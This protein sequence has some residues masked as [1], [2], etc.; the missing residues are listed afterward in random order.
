MARLGRLRGNRPAGAWEREDRGWTRRQWLRAGAAAG[1][2]IAA[3][4]VTAA[5]IL[6][7]PILPAPLIDERLRYLRHSTD[8]WWNALDGQVVRVTDFTEWSG[9]TAVWR[10]LFDR[11]DRFVSGTGYRV[12]VIRVRRDDNV[13]RASGNVTVPTGYSLFYDDPVRDVRIVVL[14]QRCTHLCCS[15]SWHVV[16]EPPPARDYE[17]YVTNPQENVPTYYVYGQDPIYCIC[18]GAQ[19]EPM[20]L[21]DGT[22]PTGPSYIGARLVHGPGWGPLPVVVVRARDDVLEGGMIDPRWYSF[23]ETLPSETS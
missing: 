4:G 12:L 2:A 9:A 8:Q 16:L 19:W 15:A 10:G 18:H 20:A 6:S 21:V 14:F 11:N 3:G 23:C 17:V 22:H 7:R 1:A 13:F 5:A